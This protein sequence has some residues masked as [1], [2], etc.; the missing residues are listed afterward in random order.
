MPP[1]PPE[2]E[3]RPHRAGRW[4]AALLL[5]L[6]AAMAGIVISLVAQNT[7]QRIF[8]NRQQR[9]LAVLADMLPSGSYNNNPATA[10]IEINAPGQLQTRAPVIAYLAGN[11]GEL[12][13]VIYAFT[14]HDGYSGDIGLLVAINAAGEL[15]AVRISRHHETPGIGARIER[16]QSDWLQ[17]FRGISSA[18][19]N[20][21]QSHDQ[22]WSAQF[23]QISGATITTSAVIAAVQRISSYHQQHVAVL[24]SEL[25]QLMA[26]QP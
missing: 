21:E 19:A 10:L 12:S 17:Q 3:H 11:D 20:Y 1:L 22:A 18:V 7:D 23:D 24:R 4:Q 26:D 13:T 9:V 15:L 5:A 16:G 8:D 6:V 2:T 14:T 25:H